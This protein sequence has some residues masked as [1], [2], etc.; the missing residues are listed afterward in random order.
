MDRPAERMSHE[1][2]ESWTARSR[3]ALSEHPVPSALVAFGLGFGFGVTLVSALA[4]T[5]RPSE[6]TAQRLGHQMIDAMRAAVPDSLS[7][8]LG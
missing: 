7:R 2:E 5:A 4:E 6:T 8:R 1:Q 3:E